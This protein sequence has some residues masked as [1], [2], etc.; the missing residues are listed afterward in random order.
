MLKPVVFPIAIKSPRCIYQQNNAH[1]YAAGLFKQC[2]LGYD[3]IP[4]PAESSDFSPVEHVKDGIGRQLHPFRN[5]DEL[6]V[7]LQKK[8]VQSFIGGSKLLY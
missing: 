5:T 6:T 3:I 2:L 4:W 1:P 8:K 7:K